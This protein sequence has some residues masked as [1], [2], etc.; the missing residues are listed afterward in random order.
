M[1]YMLYYI[2]SQ[3]KTNLKLDKCFLIKY[4]I[5]AALIIITFLISQLLYSKAAF[6]SR[7]DIYNDKIYT[8]QAKRDL[9]CLMLGYPE[10][11]KNIYKSSDGKLYVIMK[12]GKKILYDD[13]KLKTNE[14]KLANPDLQDMMEQLYPMSNISTLFEEDCDPGRIRVYPLLYEVYGSSRDTIQSNLVVIRIGY[15]NCQFNRNN[16][17]AEALKSVIN[18]L[19]PLS[20]NNP[21]IGTFIFPTSGTFNYRLVSG[22]GRLSPHSFGIA[23]D[24]KSDKNDYWKWTPRKDGQKRLNIYPRELVEIFEKHNFIWGGKW[25]HFDILHF[26]YRPELTIKG[27]LFQNPPDVSKDWFDGIPY[28]DIR[29][30]ECINMI[31][32]VIGN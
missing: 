23:I 27:R 4:Y 7:L 21:R 10:Y 6:A 29:V 26:E 2:L 12:S 14:Q 20:K 1:I 8:Y 25:G 5:V 17:A 22:T 16:G 13:M 32:N 28:N 18:E 19:I 31:D 30:S 15:Q 3:T 11:I 9:L 24:L